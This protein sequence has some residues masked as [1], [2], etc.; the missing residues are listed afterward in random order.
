MQER[1][2]L[3]DLTGVGL[4]R[5][6]ARKRNAGNTDRKIAR[7]VA[8]E[9]GDPAAH[10]YNEPAGTVVYFD[11][12]RGLV[13]KTEMDVA[14][15]N[16]DGCHVDDGLLLEYK[17]AA[18][19]LPENV[20]FHAGPGHADKVAAG[21]YQAD[22]IGAYEERL[23]DRSAGRVDQDIKRPAQACS[24][25]V[26]GCIRTERPGQT[27]RRDHEEAFAVADGQ[28]IVGRIFV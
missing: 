16:L 5:Y 19:S 9:L 27:D 3:N 14:G 4:D 22:F 7:K 10:A 24:R 13:A 12:V 21:Q 23:V 18:E 15:G 28:E 20:Q 6:G 17:V 2:A 25:N 11:E 26:Q 1:S 8:R